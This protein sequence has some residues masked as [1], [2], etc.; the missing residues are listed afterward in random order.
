MPDTT[1]FEDQ[2]RR[3][4]AQHEE[5]CRLA[6]ITCA[7][8]TGR[9]RIRKCRRNGVCSGPMLRSPRQDLRVRLQKEI[10]LSGNACA[11]L[12]VCIATG[13]DPLFARFQRAV[14][15]IGQ[16]RLDHPSFHRRYFISDFKPLVRLVGSASPFM[17]DGYDIRVPPQ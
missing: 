7:L 1:S 5:T 6:A 17:K 12:P 16:M 3:L 10:G 4:A 2:D 14:G 15:I 9:C 13:D 11:T 8:A